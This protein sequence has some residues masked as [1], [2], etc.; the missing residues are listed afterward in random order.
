MKSSLV[1]V[2]TL[3]AVLNADAQ[4]S[5]FAEI[6][7]N[8]HC[9]P[10]AAMHAAVNSHIT[11]TQRDQNVVVV[12]YHLPV[13]LDDPIYQANTVQPMQRAQTLGGVSGT[14]TTFFDGVRQTGS[15]QAWPGVL[16]R[17]IDEASPLSIS[18]DMSVSADSVVVSYTIDRGDSPEALRL[19]G[20]VVEDITFRGRN[21]VS[22]HSGAM[23][24]LLTPVQGQNLSFNEAGKSSGRLSVPNAPVWTLQ[25]LRVVL[26]LQRSTSSTSLSVLQVEPSTTSVDD[27]GTTN[28]ETRVA[29][30]D[31]S[32]AIVVAPFLSNGSVEDVREFVA[33]RLATGAYFVQIMRGDRKEVLPLLIV[34]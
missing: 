1:L 23:R 33:S 3:C 34:R 6:F 8:S 15:Y 12:Y 7:T 32:G 22:D 30:F 28:E 10:C 11:T 18:A 13:Y 16:D 26:S 19:Y 14:P 31:V 27:T 24:T 4:R 20:I 21:G 2:L 25:N 17:L 29:V 9:S 5:V